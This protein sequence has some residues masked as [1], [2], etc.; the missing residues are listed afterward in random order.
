VTRIT[1]DCIEAFAV[2]DKD[3]VSAGGHDR[4]RL[5][6]TLKLVNLS[7]GATF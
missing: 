2:E 4:V 1:P 7:L 5:R 6:D 3:H